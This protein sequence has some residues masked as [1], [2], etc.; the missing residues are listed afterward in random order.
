[1]LQSEKSF[2]NVEECVDLFGFVCANSVVFAYFL[3]VYEARTDAILVI[4]HGTKTFAAFGITYAVIPWNATAG[5]TVPF[6]TL[7]AV[8]LFAHLLILGLY[9][10]GARVRAWSVGDLWKRG[11]HITVMLSELAVWRVE[12]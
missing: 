5:Y 8:L 7:A 9:F 12:P 11:Q 2:V 3:D 1:L 10:T 4:F 6:V